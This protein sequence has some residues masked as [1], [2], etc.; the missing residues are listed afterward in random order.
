MNT[1]LLSVAAAFTLAL[2][3][4]E[5]RAQIT[6]VIGPAKRAQVSRQDSVRREEIAQDSI[7]RVT[8]TDM[9]QWV[10]SA[11]NA[12]ALRPDTGT[13]PP[14][15]TPPASTA[16]PRQQPLNPQPDSVARARQLQNAPPEFREGARAPD[17]AT[18]IPTLA[19]I[20]AT[21]LGLGL[22]VGRRRRTA[23]ESDATR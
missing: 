21:L 14:E 7:A 9:K 11:A 18:T 17:T 3:A 12:L 10:D 15:A 23:V 2:A 20:G 16:P 8:L 13:V 22:W 1:R 6:T 4:G 19:V 5:V